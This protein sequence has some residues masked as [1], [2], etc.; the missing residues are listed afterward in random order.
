MTKPFDIIVVGAGFAGTILAERF[1][2]E[3]GK[4]VLLLERREHIAGNAFDYA[5]QVGILVHKYGPKIFRTNDE[6]VWRYLHRFT[7]FNDYQHHVRARVRG[8]LLPV[9]FNLTAL[10]MVFPPA[11]AELLKTKLVRAFGMEGKVAV[12][13]LRRHPDEMLGD[14]GST[15]FRDIYLNYTV[16]QWGE[17]PE[18]LDF[19]TITRRVPVRVTY[20]NR[21]FL[22]RHQGLPAA[23]YTR[24]FEAILRHPKIEVRLDVDALSLIELDRERRRVFFEGRPFPGL[25]IFTGPVDELFGY[26]YGEL[27]YRSLELE[28]ETLDQ[29]RF[30]PVGVVN[31][32]NEEDFTRISEYKTLSMQTI[33]GKTTI[34]REYPLAY[35]RQGERGNEPYYPIPAAANEERRR[36]YVEAAAAIPSLYLIGRLAEYRYYDMNDIIQRALAAFDELKARDTSGETPA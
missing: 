11:Q 19:D 22:E 4:R 28:L 27:P 18:R 1:A 5:D 17:R 34:A 12:A 9:P 3:A 31:Y 16:K 23:G 10:E 29:D 33:P 2:A 36:Q 21:Y 6:E 7:T 8:K 14:L 25:V 13:E 26:C 35:D 15:I 30:Q 24:M 32:P 20:D